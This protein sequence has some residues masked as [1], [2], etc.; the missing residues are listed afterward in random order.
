MSELVIW[1]QEIDSLL[2]ILRLKSQQ[3][4]ITLSINQLKD[5]NLD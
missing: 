4:A 5:F 2:S 1:N 3:L